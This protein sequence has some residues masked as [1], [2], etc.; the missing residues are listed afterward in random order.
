MY[1]LRRDGGVVS[2]IVVNDVVIHFRA[3]NEREINDAK[4]ELANNGEA[5][6]A[7]H[8]P[9]GGTLVARVFVAIPYVKTYSDDHGEGTYAIV[10]ARDVEHATD[11]VAAKG[12]GLIDDEAWWSKEANEK[13]DTAEGAGDGCFYLMWSCDCGDEGC[14][15]ENSDHE[16]QTE[17][18]VFRF[19]E[20]VAYP[21]REDAVAAN[22]DREPAVEYL[23]T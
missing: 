15:D 10:R 16:S 1:G 12:G 18:I 5:S 13:G 3:D 19:D 20:A 9:C 17:T 6:S 11:L 8:D 2:F 7:I 21:T 22:D 14:R 4:E 23:E